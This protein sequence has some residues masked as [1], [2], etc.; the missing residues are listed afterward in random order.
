[1]GIFHT[2]CCTKISFDVALE[3]EHIAQ[4]VSTWKSDATIDFG[5]DG[6]IG[7]RFAQH[8]AKSSSHLGAGQVFARDTNGLSN[9]SGTCLNYT[10]CT[11]TNVL[12]CNTG[13][14]GIAHLG[15]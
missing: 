6:I 13:Q 12:R 4:I 10:K 14:F 9:G 1:M 8:L 5:R 15:R 2:P 11:T 3:L 7:D